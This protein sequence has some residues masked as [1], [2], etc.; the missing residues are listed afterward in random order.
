MVL[1]IDNLMAGICALIESALAA[2]RELVG[3]GGA[4]AH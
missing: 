3:G 4:G 1:G 2:V